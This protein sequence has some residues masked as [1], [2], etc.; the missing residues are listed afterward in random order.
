[1][2][3][4]STPTPFPFYLKCCLLR[5][6]AL[7]ILAGTSDWAFA[8]A[9]SDIQTTVGNAHV[10]LNASRDNIFCLS[11]S[12]DGPVQ[13]DS[14]IFLADPN[15]LAAS[16][17]IHQG[18]QVGL[19]TS[20]GELLIDAS[21]GHWQ[22]KDTTGQ[23][24]IAEG[25][26]PAQSTANATV[27]NITRDKDK[28]F[29]A[30]G[31]GNGTASLLKQDGSSMVG[32]GKA[33]IPYYWSPTG[34]AAFG[35]SANDE[36]P[37][38]WSATTAQG[39]VTWTF[40][41]KSASLYLMPAQTMT[42]AAQSYAD[43]TGHATVPPEWAFGY[44]QSR[45]GWESHN[46]VGMIAKQF[47]AD[48]LPVDAFI[49]D[50][51]C[52]TKTPDYDL[53]PEGLPNFPDFTWN[54]ALMGNAKDTISELLVQ[55]IH[56]V[57][58][59]KPRLGDS[60]TLQM[61][62]DKGWMLAQAQ[63][64]TQEGGWGPR[65]IN[66]A[67]PDARHWYSDHLRP[68]IEDG[69]SGWWND[70]GESSYTTY[71]YWNLAQ[72]E[73]QAKVTPA[74]RHWSIN[75][76]FQPGLQR[77]GAAAWTGDINSTWPVLT[78]TPANLLNWS[79]AGMPYGGCD[80]GGFSG[81]PS[82]EM[83]TR[84]MEAGVFFPVMR[85]HSVIHEKPHFPWLYG[86]EA[87]DAM[88][89]ALDLRYQLIPYYYSLAHETYDTGVPIMRPLAMEFPD[90]P[91]VADL[92]TQWLMGPGLMAAPILNAGGTRTVY[93]PKDTWYSFA[94]GKKLAGGQTLN[95]TAKLDE[96][97]VYVRAGTIL[98]LGPVILHTSKLPGGPLEIFVY[99]GKDATFTL[100]EDDGISHDYLKGHVRKTV[101][102]W[103]DATRTLSWK[104]EG[105][106]HGANLFQNLQTT[107]FDGT[108]KVS[109]P[110]QA[111][112]PTGSLVVSKS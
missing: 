76:A 52:Y 96:I 62:R 103:N 98:P 33:V 61:M 99:A 39:A 91:Q 67:N 40:P 59:R 22:L 74:M 44:L 5:L 75:R 81:N 69:I 63:H 28:P 10:A 45:W 97:P 55:G 13:P 20:G 27:L 41:G 4:R 37:A 24:T 95:L 53:K 46:V 111:L 30:Y 65:E 36:A 110:E 1:M 89:K 87:E 80:I 66:F 106:Y 3:L 9:I 48:R 92:S 112:T 93:L 71:Y 101:F 6:T 26:V 78:E 107:V 35:V 12:Y 90:D 60:A 86:P 84:W 43:L 17:V 73:A 50:F 109:R 83:L 108:G 51:E 68:M 102:T 94:D 54:P 25:T 11:V 32:N 14:S 29:L 77:L 82:P 104:Q 7:A 21:T 19:K 18:P 49:F 47:W 15:A 105:D 2:K 100:V 38:Q 72:V 34:Y 79:L 58:I 85:A 56:V 31:S 23:T 64:R 16:T 42:Q 8:Q 88:R 70:E 57:P